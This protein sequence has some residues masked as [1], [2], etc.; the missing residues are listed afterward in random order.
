MSN[1]KHNWKQWFKEWQSTWLWATPGNQ[2]EVC[3]KPVRRNN[4]NQIVTFHSECRAL[5]HNRKAA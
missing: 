4:Y 5:R 1:L 3:K 2:C